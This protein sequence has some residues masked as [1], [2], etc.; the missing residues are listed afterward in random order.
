MNVKNLGNILNVKY[1]TN[2]PLSYITTGQNVP[3]DIE[4][5]KQRKDSE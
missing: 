4:I 3:D 1:L 5:N 2:K